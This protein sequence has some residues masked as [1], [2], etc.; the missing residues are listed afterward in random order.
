MAKKSAAA[1]SDLSPQATGPDG[2]DGPVGDPGY[3]IT[4]PQEVIDA[5]GGIPI[6]PPPVRM[7]RPTVTRVGTAL[8]KG[9]RDPGGL[10]ASPSP[11]RRE[12]VKRIDAARESIGKLVK[13]I[14]DG[15]ATTGGKICLAIEDADACEA[16]GFDP[17]AANSLIEDLHAA[18]AKHLGESAA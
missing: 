18:L 12:A 5:I 8:P 3:P 11:K 4:V 17:I 7:D 10:L 1:D 2:I 9:R 15:L 14:E 13:T 16:E 6:P